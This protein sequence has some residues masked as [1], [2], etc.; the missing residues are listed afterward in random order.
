MMVMSP[1]PMNAPSIVSPSSMVRQI[2]S[3]T[4]QEEQ[5]DFMV[6]L[7]CENGGLEHLHFPPKAHLHPD[8]TTPRKHP[9]THSRNGRATYPVMI[10]QDAAEGDPYTVYPVQ[11][12]FGA[13]VFTTDED[14][15]YT[16]ELGMSGEA[17]ET[18][19]DYLK[20]LGDDGVLNPSNGYDEVLNAFIEGETGFIIGGPW[21]IADIKEA[22][23]NVSV[24]PIPSAGGETAQPFLG[25]QAFFIN[26][27][28][29]N[30]IAANEFVVNYLAS[31]EIQLSLYD[32]GDRTPALMA[33]AGEGA[34]DLLQ[35]GFALAG[36][37]GAQMPAIPEMASVCEFW[38]SAS[39][40]IAS[41]QGDPGELWNTMID[42][43]EN[44]FE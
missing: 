11:T 27:D 8:L 6:S 10:Q 3:A 44:S 7:G 37:S 17:G 14:G 21:M 34:S 4:G 42:N 16:S 22:G 25:V 33:A 30:P 13:P 28:A 43:V 40:G 39:I 5:V 23:V 2:T 31:E 36:E 20:K 41:G 38:G 32:A 24:H 26:A 29:E 18:F 1:S 19:A 35:E 15:N 12:S 9:L